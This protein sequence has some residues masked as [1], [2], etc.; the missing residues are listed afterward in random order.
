MDDT[1]ILPPGGLV[2]VAHVVRPHGLRGEVKVRTIPGLEDHFTI[3]REVFAECNDGAVLRLEVASAKAHGVAIIVKFREIDDRDAADGLRGATLEARMTDLP[4]LEA[5]R[6][7]RSELVG[8]EVF[9]SSGV[10]V[11]VVVRVDAYPANDVFVV[12]TDGDELLIPAVRDFIAGI[13]LGARRMTV[14]R[15]DELPRHPKHGV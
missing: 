14:L 4:E 11:G 12:D 1:G 6:Y 7:Y 3:L 2:T 10:R 8:M 9:D 5:G 13:D 15:V